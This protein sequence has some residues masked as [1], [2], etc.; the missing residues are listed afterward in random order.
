MKI[1]GF[2]IFRTDRTNDS[3]KIRG[4]CVFVDEQLCDL[5]DITTKHKSCSINVEMSS[6]DFIRIAFRENYYT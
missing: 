4:L 2:S 6:R 1:N 5:N 3:G